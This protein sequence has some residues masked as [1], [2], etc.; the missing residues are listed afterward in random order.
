MTT[1]SPEFTDGLLHAKLVTVLP[2][3]VRDPFSD[4]PRLDVPRL[5]RALKLSHEAVYRWLRSD[6]ISPKNVERIV[7]LS[8]A[9]ENRS[10]LDK[11][12]R[13]PPVL[14]DFSDFIFAAA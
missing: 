8:N 2:L 11:L 1:K 3:Y 9:D 4:A 12:G 13:T 6:R 5:H 14:K 7:A 10:I